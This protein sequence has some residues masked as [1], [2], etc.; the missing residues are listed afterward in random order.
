M[1]SNVRDA[2]LASTKR[3]YTTTEVS[4]LGTVRLQSL[5]E[6]ERAK[7]EEVAST[8]VTRMRAHLIAFA[9]VDDDGNRLFADLEVEQ[10]LK[11]DSRLTGDLSTAVMLHV[12]RQDT[13]EDQ[14]K[15]SEGIPGEPVP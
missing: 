2:L 8:D 13:T 9:L 11:M 4:G 10:I 1:T 7:I 15:N 14:L 12:G 3:R 5:T 6:L